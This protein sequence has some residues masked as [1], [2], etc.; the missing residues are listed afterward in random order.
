MKFP[1][2]LF[3]ATTNRG[4]VKEIQNFLKDFDVKIIA[5]PY[6]DVE[7]IGLSF[8]DNAIIKAKACAEFSGLPTLADDS[9][10]C[11][12]ALGGSPG[13]FSKRWIGP[14]NSYPKAFEK[15]EEELKRVDARNRLAS[16]IC[17]LVYCWPEGDTF[18]HKVFEGRVDGELTFPAKGEN[19][20]GYDP[21]FIPNGCDK[22]FAEMTSKEK[23][24]ISHRS[25]A[26]QKFSDHIFSH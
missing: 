25:L 12:W 24:E 20:F 18:S 15:I 17:S 6:P 2:E 19:N 26:L 14:E 1:K 8:E 5:G 23:G 7:E 21:I 9:G 11:I 22:T 13:I 16:F 10:L 4:K 3:L